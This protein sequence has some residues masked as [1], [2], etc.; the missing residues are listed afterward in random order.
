MSR[1]IVAIADAEPDVIGRAIELFESHL[2]GAGESVRFAIAG[3]LGGIGRPTDIDLVTLLLRDPSSRV[4]RAAVVAL[5]RLD[6]GAAAEQLRLALGDESAEV[7]VAAAGSLAGLGGA[8]CLDD[9]QHLARDEDTRVRAASIRAVGVCLARLCDEPGDEAGACD[10]RRALTEMIDAALSDD[11]VVALSAV[12]ALAE[13]GG[14]TARR[15]V[16]ALHRDEP[17]LVYEAVRCLGAHAD[18]ESLEELIALVSH[19][20]WVVRAEAIHILADRGVARAV[21]PILRRLEMEQDEFVRDGMIR[22]L[23]RLEA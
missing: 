21:P 5:V 8:V 17:E 1:A 3:L 18:E 23:Q 2:Q 7:R 12:E 14:S 11:A 10:D 9:L 19:A 22:A 16:A 15:A 6:P 20:D 13:V 4:R